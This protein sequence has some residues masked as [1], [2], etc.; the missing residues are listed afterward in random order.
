[1]LQGVKR[2]SIKSKIIKT[3]TNHCSTRRNA[4]AT[5]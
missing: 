1:M 2:Q 5:K 3:F 4:D